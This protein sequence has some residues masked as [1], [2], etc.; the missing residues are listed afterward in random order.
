M[1]KS[2]LNASCRKTI[3][4]HFNAFNVS[5]VANILFYFATS[6]SILART[7]WKAVPPCH[8]FACPF[9]LL[10]ERPRDFS[11]L[12][13]RVGFRH[14]YVSSILNKLR[15]CCH[16]HASQRANY[17]SY[18]YHWNT[19]TKL[20]RRQCGSALKKII[21]CIFFSPPH[22]SILART[23]QLIDQRPSSLLKIKLK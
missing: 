4:V 9:V 6:Y 7:K 1:I 5:E 14:C 23:L 17:I 15:S 20:T 3:V 18:F 16:S 8:V 19:S 2:S 12:P 11:S 21:I 10:H 13:S 22:F